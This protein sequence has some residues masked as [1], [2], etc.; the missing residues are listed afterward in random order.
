MSDDDVIPADPHCSP[1]SVIVTFFNDFC[2]TWDMIGAV[3]YEPDDN[4]PPHSD[5]ASGQYRFCWS[6]SAI[7][8]ERSGPFP[9]RSQ[10]KPFR[11]RELFPEIASRV[12][13]E[14]GASL[15][16]FLRGEPAEAPAPLIVSLDAFDLDQMELV[17]IPRRTADH[18]FV[19]TFHLRA[20]RWSWTPAV[21]FALSR[22]EPTPLCVMRDVQNE[23]DRHALALRTDDDDRVLLGYIPRYWT[24]DVAWLLDHVDPR[25]LKLLLP[26]QPR[27]SSFG[28]AIRIVLDAPWPDDFIPC[29]STMHRIVDGIIRE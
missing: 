15:D 3:D 13:K 18:R 27:M 16:R 7:Q 12:S 5:D 8:A 26:C 20:A 29:Q 2:R 25:Q 17:P 22:R 11:S 6:D 28:P 19:L 24:H 9:M 14:Y 10:P 1:G 4:V 23:W 21:K